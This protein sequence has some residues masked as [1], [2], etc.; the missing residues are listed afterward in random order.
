MI[1]MYWGAVKAV[2]RKSCD[3]TFKTL[4]TTV[5]KALMKSTN[6]SYIFMNY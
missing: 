5:P 4:Q 3:Y 1:E 2:T 6:W